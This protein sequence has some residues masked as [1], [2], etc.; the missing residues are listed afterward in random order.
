[1]IKKFIKP[2]FD[3]IRSATTGRIY[4]IAEINPA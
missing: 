4:R 3:T 2:I 1:M